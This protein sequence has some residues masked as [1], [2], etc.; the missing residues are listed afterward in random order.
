VLLEWVRPEWDI[1]APCPALAALLLELAV[2]KPLLYVTETLL[3]GRHVST[4]P[5]SDLIF[6]FFFPSV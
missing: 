1:R 3:K 4:G 6:G 5:Y 2:T